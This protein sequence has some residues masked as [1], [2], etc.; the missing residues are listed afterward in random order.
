MGAA[1]GARPFQLGEIAAH[2]DLGNT[3]RVGKIANAHEAGLVEPGHEVGLTRRRSASATC[4][5]DDD[6]FHS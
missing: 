5:G 2:R 3:G 4:H 6:R 1:D